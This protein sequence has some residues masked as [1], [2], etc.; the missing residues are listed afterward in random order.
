MSATRPSRV[1]VA[2]DEPSIRFVL[3]EILE[4]SGCQ[5]AEATDGD[6]AR[7]AL[8]SDTF[9]LAFLDIRM[10]GPTGL[11]LLDAVRARGADTAVV[12]ITAQN[13]F[14]NAV[15]AMRHQTGGEVLLTAWRSDDGALQVEVLD[16][17]PGVSLDLAERA[18]E[19]FHT[20]KEAGTGLGL[21]I[22][23]H[24]VEAHGGTVTLASREEG[25][26]AARFTLPGR[27]K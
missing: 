3:R 12:I 7:E 20:T 18:F 10:P 23:R 14:E 6:A 21:S 25:G 4:E 2:D 9:Q 17:G 16:S 22:V 15:E 11:D 13:T 19:P 24:I 1:L 26:A 27:R 5:V 8:A